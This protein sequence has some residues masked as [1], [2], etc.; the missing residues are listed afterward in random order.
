MR[1]L[2]LFGPPL[3]ECDKQAIDINNGDRATEKST[4]YTW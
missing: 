2:M 4:N 3:S 1:A